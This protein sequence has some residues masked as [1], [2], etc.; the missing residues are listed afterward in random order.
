MINDTPNALI[1]NSPTT[2]AV[3]GINTISVNPPL[4]ISG[5]FFVGVRQTG[6][7]N[8]GFGYQNENPIR[9]NTFYY[10][11][12]TVTNWNDF[13]SNSFHDYWRYGNLECSCF[14]RGSHCWPV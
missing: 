14:V 11:A 1:W 7:T 13:A 12:T 5:S 9:N 4:P 2:V 6:I 8:V 10:K 3:T